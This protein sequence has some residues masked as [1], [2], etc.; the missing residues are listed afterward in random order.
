MF[1]D[2]Y[3]LVEDGMHHEGSEAFKPGVV[4]EKLNQSAPP[5]IVEQS[6]DEGEEGYIDNGTG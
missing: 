4:S 3:A 1:V 2:P 6:G 5:D